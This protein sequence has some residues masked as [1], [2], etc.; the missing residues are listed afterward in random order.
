MIRCVCGRTRDA[1]INAGFNVTGTLTVDVLALKV[2]ELTERSNNVQPEGLTRYLIAVREFMEHISTTTD[3]VPVVVPEPLECEN[4]SAYSNAATL[5]VW[6]ASKICTKLEQQECTPFYTRM[7]VYWWSSGCFFSVLTCIA[8]TRIFCLSV[9]QQPNF[10]CRLFDAVCS[11]RPPRGYEQ[12]WRGLQ[13]QFAKCVARL[14]RAC[15]YPPPST[16]AKALESFVYVLVDQHAEPFSAMELL[17]WVFLC[18]PVEGG[19]G[20]LHPARLH[21]LA[22]ACATRHQSVEF[23]SLLRLYTR[24][25]AYAPALG[26][27]TTEASAAVMHVCAKH[28]CD[29]TNAATVTWCWEVLQYCVPECVAHLFPPDVVTHVLT[30]SMFTLNHRTQ[31][32]V[33]AFVARIRA[34]PPSDVYMSEG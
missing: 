8:C 30:R 4:V 20:L 22:T 24:V 32:I 9:L 13:S 16:H 25:Q 11:V 19:C 34:I 27:G 33:R 23:V 28:V 14:T 12:Q 10:A 18:A 21:K 5:C 1:C 31:N 15:P 29:D 3:G 17:S 2:H 7:M 6:A 26:N